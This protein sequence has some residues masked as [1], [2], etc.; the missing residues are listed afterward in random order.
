M[1]DILLKIIYCTTWPVSSLK[2]LY[3]KCLDPRLEFRKNIAPEYIK[4]N[5]RADHARLGPMRISNLAMFRLLLLLLS[6][7]VTKVSI[8]GNWTGVSSLKKFRKLWKIYFF[9]R[10]LK[11]CPFSCGGSI[12]W[13]IERQDTIP[14]IIL[15]PG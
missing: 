6:D 12:R 8:T 7:R 4:R 3:L 5:Q 14:E 1:T 11:H 2:L 13:F 15:S 9:P 10:P